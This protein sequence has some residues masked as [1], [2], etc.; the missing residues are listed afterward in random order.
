MHSH[1]WGS[2]RANFMMTSILS[3]ESLVRVLH[4]HTHRLL[5]RLFSNKTKKHGRTKNRTKKR[6]QSRLTDLVGLLADDNALPLAPDV[7]LGVGARPQQRAIG[8]LHRVQVER[9]HVSPKHVVPERQAHP[10]AV[11]G[12]LHTPRRTEVSVHSVL[13]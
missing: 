6:A 2:Y 12:R 9:L 1:V 5:P 11:R 10:A 8:A 7:A 13:P 4:T 3:E